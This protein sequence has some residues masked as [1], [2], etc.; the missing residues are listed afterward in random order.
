MSAQA[1]VNYNRMWDLAVGQSVDKTRS[2]V[3][4][5]EAAR[6]EMG[7][8]WDSG[9]ITPG[10]LREW[11]DAGELDKVVAAVP[12]ITAWKMVEA[13]AE[14]GG[15]SLKVPKNQPR[16]PDNEPDSREREILAIFENEGLE[17]YSFVDHDQNAVRYFRP[18]RLTRECLLCHGD[19]A[20]SE[21][22]W[23]NTAGLDPTGTRMENWHEGEVHGA[24]EIIQSL[25]ATQAMIRATMWRNL[26][27][28]AVLGLLGMGLFAWTITSA[29][30]RPIFRVISRLRNNAE[31]VSVFSGQVAD[32][33]TNLANSASTQAASLEEISASLTEITRLTTANADKA[34]GVNESVH[35]VQNAA[36]D[37]K[38]AMGRMA[39]AIEKIR[40]GAEQ[41]TSIVGSIDAIAFQTNLLALNAAVE[42]AR[43]GDA[44]KGF[45]VV[46][47]E[48][49]NLAR[50]SADAASDTT[51]ILAESGESSQQ[52]VVI[53][54]EVEKCLER[55]AACV[56]DMEAMVRDVSHASM[57]QARGVTEINAAVTDMD[58]VT[59]GNAASAEESAAGAEE[60]A[61][62]AVELNGLVG[63]LVVVVAGRSP[64]RPASSGPA[65][66]HG[67][68]PGGGASAGRGKGSKPLPNRTAGPRKAQEVL[69][70]E[71]EEILI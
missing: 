52:G 10:M 26:L 61:A 43:A 32:S 5:A 29:V 44:G 40:K 4:M 7:N 38:A 50:R 69:R 67:G 15:F 65:T 18:I 48:V 49:R 27:I 58:H 22:I 56:D 6:E 36:S 20:T 64:G 47:E 17:E 14:A 1:V 46:A 70:L 53:A 2:V 63:E 54:G 12:V 37:G 59:Q 68:K 16:N 60:L 21:E 23:G 57:E 39:E 71:E 42:A 24:F 9:L 3:L 62:Q 33:G 25:D 28:S 13:K 11:A 19:P 8:K 55:I 35:H 31:Q 45:A 34:D 41:S 51:R 30:T 66:G